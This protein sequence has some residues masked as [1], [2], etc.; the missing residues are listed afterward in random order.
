MI[1]LGALP[2]TPKASQS[3]AEII[4]AACRDA[5]ALVQGGVTALLV[6]NMHDRPYLKGHVGPEIVASITACCLALKNS[7]IIPREMTM[8]LQILAAANQE[9]LAVA[10]AAQ[11][12]FI[13]AEGFVF[14]H[15]ADEG[16]IQAQAGELLRYRKAIGADQVAIFT[17]IKK[18]HS[19]HA[20]TA[21]VDL[22]ETAHAAEYFLADGL[23]VTG[24]RTAVPPSL[25]EL[26]AVRQASHLPLLVGSGVAEDNIRSFLAVADAV[27]VGSSVKQKGDWRMP[28]DRE[29]VARLVDCVWSCATIW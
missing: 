24:T 27:I 29:A 10:Q 2:G 18:K 21:D 8:G 16:L 3:L 4:D 22:A 19:S 11:L 7:G 5:Q 9:A 23:I 25:A 28:V 13:R 1:H 6:E 14:A 20:I 17:D 26:E 12:D 15:V